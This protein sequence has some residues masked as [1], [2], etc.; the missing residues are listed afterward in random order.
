MIDGDFI[1]VQ[2]HYFYILKQFHN[3]LTNPFYK[4][5]NF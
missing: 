2:D 1:N 5:S 3:S 4:Y